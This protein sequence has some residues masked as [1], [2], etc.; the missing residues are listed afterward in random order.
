MFTMAA[1]H[2]ERWGSALTP[3]IYLN[4]H[5]TV[6]NFSGKAFSVA[7]RDGKGIPMQ[8]LTLSLYSVKALTLS[9]IKSM[10]LKCTCQGIWEK[11]ALQ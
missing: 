8:W 7:V 1:K 11:C 6:V 4:T 3:S 10:V 9:D 2:S 5:K